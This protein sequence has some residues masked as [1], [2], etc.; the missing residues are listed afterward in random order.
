MVQPSENTVAVN[1]EIADKHDVASQNQL[2]CNMCN[3]ADE[4]QAL[5][6]QIKRTDL[7]KCDILVWNSITAHLASLESS[8]EPYAYLIDLANATGD[9]LTSL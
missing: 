6:D 2:Y 9:I 3:F 1:R 7:A 5:T 4:I 8:Q